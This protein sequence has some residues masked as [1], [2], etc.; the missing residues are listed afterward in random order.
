MGA[1]AVQLTFVDPLEPRILPRGGWPIWTLNVKSA[2]EPIRQYPHRLSD[3]DW[4]LWRIN[5]DLDTYM[6]QGFF[7]RPAGGRCMS[8]AHAE[9]P[10][11]PHLIGSTAAVG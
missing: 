1:P 5:R 4:V 7:D 6:S 11:V 10:Q 2:D 8:V 3:L 9:S